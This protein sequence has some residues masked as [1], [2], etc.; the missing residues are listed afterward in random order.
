MTSKEKMEMGASPFNRPTANFHSFAKKNCGGRYMAKTSEARFEGILH[1]LE[2]SE[3][4]PLRP[5]LK[6]A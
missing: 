3:R 4:R 2:P 6:K 5:P 1:G